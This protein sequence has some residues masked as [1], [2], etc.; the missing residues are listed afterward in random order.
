MKIYDVKD[1]NVVMDQHF[2]FFIMEQLFL[3]VDPKIVLAV[4]SLGSR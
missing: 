1:M 4:I 3:N 2:F